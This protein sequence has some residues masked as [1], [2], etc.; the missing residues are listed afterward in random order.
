MVI[1]CIWYGGK[2]ESEILLFNSFHIH[3]MELPKLNLGAGKPLTHVQTARLDGATPPATLTD[4]IPPALWPFVKFCGSLNALFFSL[5][6]CRFVGSSICPFV[7]LSVFMS[8]QQ[9]RLIN[10][11]GPLLIRH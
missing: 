11:R 6:F 8:L 1:A 3:Y 7:G 10:A 2:N 9:F 5:S 4:L